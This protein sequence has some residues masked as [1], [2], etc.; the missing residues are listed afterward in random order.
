M[1]MCVFSQN[2]RVKEDDVMMGPMLRNSLLFRKNA[3]GSMLDPC[4]FG[5]VRDFYMF[6]QLSNLTLFGFSCTY[7]LPFKSLGAVRFSFMFLNM[8]LY[9]INIFT[10]TFD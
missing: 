10:V 4:K 6:L 8:R 5:T 9:V 7:L 2:S 1:C 3:F